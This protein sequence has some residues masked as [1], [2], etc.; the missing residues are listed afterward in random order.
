MKDGIIEPDSPEARVFGFTSD[1]F[2]GYL[3]KLENC[4]WISLVL[5]KKPG[6]S[7][8]SKLLGKIWREGYSIKVP[9][10]SNP[11]KAILSKKGFTETWEDSELGAVEVWVK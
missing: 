5:S 6:Q 10:P 3:W 8:F 11:M 7:N 1:K 4:I 9:T 2:S